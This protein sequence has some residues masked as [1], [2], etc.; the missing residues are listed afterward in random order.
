[1]NA[2]S[3]WISFG[4][5]DAGPRSRPEITSSPT[6]TT[7][8]SPSVQARPDTDAGS[9]RM[10]I[11]RAAASPSWPVSYVPSGIATPTTSFPRICPAK[12]FA[13]RSDSMLSAVSSSAP[14]AETFAFRMVPAQRRTLSASVPP[15]GAA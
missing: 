13:L 9:R 5:E 15:R 6:R 7:T 14:D 1:M 11:S 2:S 8:R 4:N 10:R 3:K 12:H